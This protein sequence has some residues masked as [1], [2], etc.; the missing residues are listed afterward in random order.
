MGG[1]ALCAT[2]T[3]VPAV[4]FEGCAEVPATEALF[5]SRKAR[6]RAVGGLHLKVGMA[7]I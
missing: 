1:V 7:M 6:A 3:A 5:E 4:Y 2:I